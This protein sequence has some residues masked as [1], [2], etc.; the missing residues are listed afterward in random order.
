M[1]DE[2]RT[3]RMADF[4][5]RNC[6]TLL[7]YFR[8]DP[9]YNTM[10][11]E[12]EAKITSAAFTYSLS[13]FIEQEY[14]AAQHLTLPILANINPPVRITFVPREYYRSDADSES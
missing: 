12:N 4:L 13:V 14:T 10:I 7:C 11:G 2:N 9:I 5:L 1:P 3:L 8:C 6:A